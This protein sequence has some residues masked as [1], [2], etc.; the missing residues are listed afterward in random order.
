MDRIPLINKLKTRLVYTGKMVVGTYSDIHNQELLLP[1][2]SYRFSSPYYEV[3]VGLENI[4]KFIRI[5][6]I[7]RLSYRNNVNLYGE[8]VTNFGIKFM[9][10][11]DF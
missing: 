3:G 7:W 2:Y 6:A 10:T 1:F 11:S 9:F 4:L 5:D 8:Q